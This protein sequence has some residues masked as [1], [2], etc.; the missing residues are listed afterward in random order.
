MGVR[1]AIAAGWG[2][3]ARPFVVVPAPALPAAGGGLAGLI[4]DR[5]AALAR[6]AL[7]VDARV[8]ALARDGRPL[9]VWS[10]DGWRTAPSRPRLLRERTLLVNV[11]ALLSAPGDAAEWP[12]AGRGRRRLA[13]DLGRGEAYA[14][15]GDAPF[16]EAS[17]R[18]AAWLVERERPA[19]GRPPLPE[20]T[21]ITPFPPHADM[22]SPSAGATD[23]GRASA[24][25][26]A[27]VNAALVEILDAGIARPSGTD[28]LAEALV[29]LR[30]RSTVPWLFNLLANEVEYEAGRA[31]LQSLPPE[32]HLS[33]TSGCNIE[34]GFCTYTHDKALFDTTGLEDVE[35]IGFAR[36]THT[37]RLSSGL[38]EPTMVRALPQMV[39]LLA[40]RFPHLR[41][42]FFTNGLSL[43]REALV[44]ALVDRVTWIN[45]SLNAATRGTWKEVCGTDGFDRM[46]GAVASLRDAKRAARRVHPLLFGSAVVTRRSLGDLVRL[47]ELCRRLGVDRLTLIP[48]FA[49]EFDG[50]GKLGPEDA[51]DGCRPEYDASYE[52]IVA[53]A[54]RHRVSLELPLPSTERRACFGLE[55]RRFHDFARIGHEDALV[56]GPLVRGLLSPP[57]PALCH[58]LWRLALVGRVDTRHRARAATSHF[59][60]P[61]LGPL[62][63]VDFS[64]QMA[65]R[66]SGEGE[67][68]SVWNHPTLRFLRAAQR[69]PGASEVCDLCRAGDTR[70][71]AAFAALKRSLAQW[72]L[73]P[74]QTTAGM[75]R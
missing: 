55:L 43:G 56:I 72:P 21:A 69:R 34:C 42:N 37:L 14:S 61:C 57:A 16:D 3:R 15:V 52:A 18:L 58:W 54:E 12:A 48:F 32:V 36:H 5:I 1:E 45:V 17:L 60:Y 71:P 44:Q 75:S 59:L 68:A 29:M 19:D 23:R 25:S 4:L 24:L 65:F 9:L 70:Q 39:E 33:L 26:P 22:R 49:L 51:L 38:G 31:E 73:P 28:A 62:V 66:F 47:P 2:R 46:C 10:E 27:V 7:G 30:G 50:P 13:V 20:G 40:G 74:G 53:E 11:A 6:D 67:L 41:M 8:L 63:T 35:S 64:E